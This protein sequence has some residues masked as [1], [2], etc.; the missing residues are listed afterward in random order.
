[1]VVK[2]MRFPIV[3]C[4]SCPRYDYFRND[5]AISVNLD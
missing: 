3:L 2:Y 4:L 5:L 1:V